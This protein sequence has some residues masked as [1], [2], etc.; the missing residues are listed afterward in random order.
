MADY[1][2]LLA[3]ALDALPDRSADLR[4]A[5]YDRARGALIGQLRSIVP[6][7]SEVD[8]DRERSA[9]EAAIE[10]LEVDY[11][12]AAIAPAAPVPADD[13]MPE[14]LPPEPPAP[15]LPPADP[16]LPEPS[17]LPPA[18]APVIPLPPR[19]LKAP[20]AVEP[21]RDTDGTPPQPAPVD[22]PRND[23]AAAIDPAARLDEESEAGTLPA[24]A[25]NGRQRPRID[26]VAPRRSNARLLRNVF[27]GS[28]LAIVIGLIA[29]AAYLL[30]DR[31]SDLQPV[32][33][34]SQ[35]A[36][37]DGADTKFADRIGGEAA[38][39]ERPATAPAANSG[40][41]ALPTQPEVAVAQRAVLIEE[42]RDNPSAAPAVTQG[43]AVWRLDVVNGEQGQPLETAVRATIDFPDAGLSLA[44][45]MRRNLDATLPASHTIELAFTNTGPAGSARAVQ[46]VGLIQAK[47]EENARGSPLSGLP[48]KVR[49]NLFLIG[50][51]S[52]R[53][54]VERNTDLLL[55]KGWF[56][57]ALK[58][59]AGPRAVITFEKG[60]SGIQVIQNAFNQWRR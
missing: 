48:V 56:D 5:V 8:I 6:P 12:G 10:R 2:P 33:G 34:D 43:R 23:A 20:V 37:A 11:G 3:R 59:S 40:P 1:Y 15:V 46:D 42:N 17:V 19:A 55:H 35:G 50:L 9:L 14:P 28:V 39:I 51:S 7:L 18:V 21:I 49:E 60:S 30:R 38:P 52:L 54:D 53:N 32:A 27:V 31:P 36:P 41:P 4:K 58:F 57:L 26:V 24:D 29:T 44:M 13:P 16:V 47:D 45:T 22:A 25:A